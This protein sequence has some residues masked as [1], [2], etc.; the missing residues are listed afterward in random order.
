MKKNR[1]K[2]KDT[3]IEVEEITFLVQQ[4]Y[5]LSHLQDLKE[6]SRIAKKYNIDP[7]N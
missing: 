4:F 5:M 7:F 1:K 6:V 3:S 2:I